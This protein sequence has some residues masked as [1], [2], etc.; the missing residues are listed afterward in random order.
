MAR[1]VESDLTKLDMQ[2]IAAALQQYL[3][4]SQKYLEP[5]PE[6]K[7]D[8]K[9]RIEQNM[10]LA[11]SAQQKF[12]AFEQDMQLREIRMAY[13]CVHNFRHRL[14]AILAAQNTPDN[15][16]VSA[17][18]LQQPSESAFMKL[19]QILVSVGDNPANYEA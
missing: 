18:K 9:Q 14:S 5:H 7:E 19:H 15:V 2:A 1:Q 6:V 3:I 11:K 12:S 8:L 4:S 13:F 17:Q 10:E 16:R